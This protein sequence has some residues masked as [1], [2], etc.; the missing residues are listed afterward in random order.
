MPT[1]AL[2]RVI[3]RRQIYPRVDLH[4]R[5]SAMLQILKVRFKDKASVIILVAV[6]YV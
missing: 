5:I 2:V 3:T 4:L 6:H 1:M